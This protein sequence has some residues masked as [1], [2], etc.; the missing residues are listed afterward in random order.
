MIITPIAKFLRMLRLNNNEVLK[1][2]ADKLGLSTALISSIETGRK[3]ASDNFREKVINKY[4]LSNEEIKELDDAIVRTN[5][6][7][8]NEVTL[9]TN[10][11]D[12]NR[13]DLAVAFA[14]YFSD[15]DEDSTNKIK[16]ILEKNNKW[17]LFI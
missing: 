11:L 8:L 10:N 4:N 13:E 17:F 16:K 15:L 12:E 14:R 2:M 7:E 3:K 6:R 1:D 9:K 5:I